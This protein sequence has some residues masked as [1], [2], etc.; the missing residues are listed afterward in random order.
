MRI[1][2]GYD[3]HC[4]VEGRKLILGGVDVPYER[5][6]LGH[7][8]ADVL[9]HAIADAILG[10][11]ALGDIG[12]HFPDTDP[13]FKGADSRKLLRH[14]MALAGQKGYVLGNVDA[15][16]VAQR[17]K[18]APFIPEMRANLAE[19]LTAE[20]DRINVKA[21]TTEQLGFAGRGEGIAAY[22]VVLM[23]RT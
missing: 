9:L 17:P 4:L 23:E 12:K 10:A 5:G 14:V 13:Q 19:D 2:H 15:T 16:M 3:V 20:I 22:A 1:G 8:D 6:L 18:L 21:T 11:L 7:S